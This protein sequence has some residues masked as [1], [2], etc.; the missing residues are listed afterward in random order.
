MKRSHNKMPRSQR[1]KQFL[2][3]AAV[4]GL[5]EALRQVEASLMAS[6]RPVLSE[7]SRE[8]MD[9]TLSLLYEEYRQVQIRLARLRHQEECLF[10][11]T[12]P[13]LPMVTVT[14]YDKGVLRQQ[15]GVLSRLDP[16]SRILQVVKTKIA[17][18][19]LISIQKGNDI[20]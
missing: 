1:A 8:E 13:S 2:P 18:S 16:T 15:Y 11:D 6:P 12:M 10:G 20:K 14:Y 3:F 7:E 4:R 5:D 17:F 19:D 9:Q